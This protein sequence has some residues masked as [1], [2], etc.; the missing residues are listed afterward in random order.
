MVYE[1]K[2]NILYIYNDDMLSIVQTHNPI[3][4][5]NF[6][7]KEDALNWLLYHINSSYGALPLKLNLN[8]SNINEAMMLPDKNTVCAGE[9]FKIIF[10]FDENCAQNEAKIFICN[11][12]FN[13]SYNVNIINSVASKNIIIEEPG[14]YKV[15]LEAWCNCENGKRV[16]LQDL[17]EFTIEVQ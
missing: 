3:T 6:K 10:N 8:V 13:K 2:D 12:D 9:P 15:H 16:T 17:N 1:F 5:N 7:D 4:G 11:E 14:T